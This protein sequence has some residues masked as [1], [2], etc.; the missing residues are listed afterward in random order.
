MQAGKVLGKCV[1]EC[2]VHRAVAGDDGFKAV[3][4]IPVKLRPFSSDVS[5]DLDESALVKEQSHS[6]PCAELSLFRE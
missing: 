1:N 4:G 2:S 3:V 6:L 5:A